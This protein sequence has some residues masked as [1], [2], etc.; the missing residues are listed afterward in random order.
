MNAYRYPGT[1]SFSSDQRHLFF[2]RDEDMA[3]LARLVE[4]EKVSVLYGKSGMGKTSLL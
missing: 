4:L 2:G 1:Y 3:D